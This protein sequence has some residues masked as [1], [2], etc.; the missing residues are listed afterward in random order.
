MSHQ[1]LRELLEAE[2][3]R[4]PAPIADP[5]TPEKRFKRMRRK[6]G[7]ASILCEGDSWFDNIARHTTITGWW[8]KDRLGRDPLFAVLSRAHAASTAES[9]AARINQLVNDTKKYKPHGVALSVGGNDLL[10]PKH[11]ESLIGPEGSSRAMVPSQALVL[12]KRLFK[13]MW[14]I[15][16][17]LDHADPGVPQF[18]H[19]YDYPQPSGIGVNLGGIPLAG[20]WLADVLTTKGYSTSSE[21]RKVVK[22]LLDEFFKIQTEITRVIRRGNNGRKPK[23]NLVNLRNTLPESLEWPDE[24]HPSSDGF[25]MLAHRYKKAIASKLRPL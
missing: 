7:V 15:T 12:S 22:Q 9:V 1:A 4:S 23:L 25:H 10:D 5:M 19:S 17:K 21:K 6:S 11:I 24:I 20:P 2:R 18:W 14:E 8:W 3:L 13:N 16:S